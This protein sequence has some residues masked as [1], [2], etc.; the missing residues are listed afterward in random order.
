VIYRDNYMPR[1][2]W[3]EEPNGNESKWDF[4]QVRVNGPLA[5]TD[6]ATP[7]TPSGW[8]MVTMPQQPQPRIY[9]PQQK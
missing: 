9:R 8:R 5:A 6:F 4:P 1:E 2:L 3:F 7:P